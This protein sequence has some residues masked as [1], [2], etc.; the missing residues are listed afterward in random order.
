MADVSI[1]KHKKKAKPSTPFLL[2]T[3]EHTRTPEG[4]P[5]TLSQS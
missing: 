2:R 4:S 5:V 1:G 3:A